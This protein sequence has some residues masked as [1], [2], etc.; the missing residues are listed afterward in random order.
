MIAAFATIGRA[1]RARLL[2]WLAISFG[3]VVVYYAGLLASLSFQF[4]NWPNYATLYD[5][6]ANIARIFA[7]TPSLTDALDIARDEW[8]FEVGYMNMDYGHGISEWSLTLLPAK[9]LI[10]LAMGMA[11]ATVWALGTAR[12]GACSLAERGTAVATTSLGVGLIGLTGATMT[13][14]VCCAT[15]SWIVGLTMLGLSVATANWLEPFGVWLK[16]GGLL[17][18]GATAFVMAYRMRGQVAAAMPKRPERP[19]FRA[20]TPAEAQR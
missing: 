8:L 2:A 9:M 17:L 3:C 14:V 18:L 1:I 20:A 16:T 4:G 13:W 5:W 7:S 19:D 15:P 11:V 10:I 6:P 12:A